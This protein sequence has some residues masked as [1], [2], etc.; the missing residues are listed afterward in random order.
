MI[1]RFVRLPDGDLTTLL[2]DPESIHDYL[3]PEDEDT[4]RQVA[5]LDVDKAWHG[6]HWLLTGTTWGGDGPTAFIMRG[7]E[8]VGDEPVG[9]GPARGFTAEEVRG[10]A[11][12]LHGL[13]SEILHARFDPQAMETADIYP[14]EIWM[15][16]GDEAFEYL[17]SY[18]DQLKDFVLGAAKEGE[19]L[20]IYIA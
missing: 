18:F 1:G 15:R 4:S 9:Q 5:E 2:A 7:G 16:E 6:I 8:Q 17:D 20:L 19:A 12:A 3:Y 14:S 13:S 11:A 10:I